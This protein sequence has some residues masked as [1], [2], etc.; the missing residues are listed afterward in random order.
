MVAHS[1]IAFGL[2][3][4]Q[5]MPNETRKCPRSLQR[6]K[7]SNIHLKPLHNLI[8]SLGRLSAASRFLFGIFLVASVGPLPPT[9]TLYQK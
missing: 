8:S 7:P 6:E 5:R 1:Y 3:N 2:F 4:C 9:T